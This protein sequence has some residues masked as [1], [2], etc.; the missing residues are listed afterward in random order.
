[1]VVGG[2]A[3]PG[4]K[5]RG[6]GRINVFHSSS[7]RQPAHERP[8]LPGVDIAEVRQGVASLVVVRSH[9][10]LAAAERQRVDSRCRGEHHARH[11]DHLNVRRAALRRNQDHVTVGLWLSQVEAIVAVL[12]LRRV[13]VVHGVGPPAVDPQVGRDVV[14]ITRLGSIGSAVESKANPLLTGSV[15]LHHAAPVNRFS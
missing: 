1:M 5:N 2:L 3:Q 9:R 12:Q 11:A 13:G 8:Q 15:F 14:G 4:L 6:R 7:R 10:H